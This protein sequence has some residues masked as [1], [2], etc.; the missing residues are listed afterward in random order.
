MAFVAT[1]FPVVLE[2][3]QRIHPTA[4]P[5]TTAAIIRSSIDFLVYHLIRDLMAI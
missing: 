3:Y 1:G 4:E 5:I 2:I